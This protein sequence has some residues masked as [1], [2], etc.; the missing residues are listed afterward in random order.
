M[1]ITLVIISA[2]RVCSFHD[3]QGRRPFC[4]F[5]P[6]P[7]QSGYPDAWDHGWQRHV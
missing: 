5:W 7:V 6:S 4:E 2:L 1:F 3:W